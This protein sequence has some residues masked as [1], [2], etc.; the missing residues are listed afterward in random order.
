M[1]FLDNYFMRQALKEAIYA[2][3][4][5][6]IPVGA[7]AVFK[8]KIIAQAHN[9][10]KKLR[11]ATAHAE[12]Q[13]IGAAEFYLKGKFK[14]LKDC[15]LYVTLEPCLMC[16]GAIFLAKLGSLVFGAS[17]ISF[18]KVIFTKESSLLLESFFK[19][20]RKYL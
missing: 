9:L 5:N 12:I 13:V 17:N 14:S 10:T 8:N 6:E 20:N 2:Y 19:K 4:K 18:N 1:K 11:D 7:I 3:E 15:C 16:S